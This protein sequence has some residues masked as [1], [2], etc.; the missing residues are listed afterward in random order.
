MEVKDCFFVT[1]LLEH[2]I[3]VLKQKEQSD[4]V[5]ALISYCER[6]LEIMNHITIRGVSMVGC[7]MGEFKEKLVEK[8]NVLILSDEELKRVNKAIRVIDILEKE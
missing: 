5:L 1:S 4:E 7:T 6:E 3:K 8:S 2:E